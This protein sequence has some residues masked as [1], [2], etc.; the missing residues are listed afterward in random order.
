[1]DDKDGEPQA[2]HLSPS[3]LSFAALS[4]LRHYLRSSP[5][6]LLS[7]PVIPRLETWI[8]RVVEGSQR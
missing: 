4:R 5:S 1:L 8:Y 6:V 7:V 3:A 2:V